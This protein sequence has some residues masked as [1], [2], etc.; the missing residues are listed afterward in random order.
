MQRGGL[1]CLVEVDVIEIFS[2][3]GK[4][5]LAQ[6]TIHGVRMM[7]RLFVIIGSLF[8]LTQV[9]SAKTVTY[10][11]ADTQGSI[12]ATA[13]SAGAI[14]SSPDYRSFGRAVGGVSEGPAYT[15]HFDDGDTGLVY[16]KARF[17]DPDIGRFL[18]R[19]PVAVAAGDLNSVNRFAY[20]GNNPWSRTDPSGMYI[21]NGDAQRC[22]MVAVAVG[23]IKQAANALPEG[24]SQQ[25]LVR[26]V[27]EFYGA[28]G[29]DN[30]VTVSFGAT[31]GNAAME[32]LTNYGDR[33]VSITVNDG[34][35]Q[36]LG[37]SK[38]LEIAALLAHEGNHGRVGQ[39]SR[40]N[41]PGSRVEEKGGEQWSYF[42][43][44]YV[45]KGLGSDSSYDLWK[46]GDADVNP[47]RVEHWSEESAKIWCQGNSL[48]H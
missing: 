32:T 27:S 3:W 10:Y 16:M 6:D 17:Y 39:M 38:P 18:S 31:R 19:D 25:T 5:T 7:K 42:I 36:R 13:D 45:N 44:G 29:E 8:L 23:Q 47:E 41:P 43:Q 48:C 30:K 9:A 11:Y 20:V 28:E 15:S 37:K 40:S 22:E 24:S 12:L 26:K 46:Q 2:Y 1:L 34:A 4:V 33:S 21:C 35:M 14:T